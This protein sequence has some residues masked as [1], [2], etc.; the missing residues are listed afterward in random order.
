MNTK[1]AFLHFGGPF[2][3]EQP[4]PRQTIEVE[5]KEDFTWWQKR[6]LLY[7]STGYGRKIPTTYKVKFENRWY[8]V[9]CCIYS[10]SGVCY[11]ISRGK[12]LATV[13]IYN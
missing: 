5:Y 2:T 7:T 8:R 3:T 4:A 9:Y 6:G 12:P 10:N 11:I 1:Q 13:D